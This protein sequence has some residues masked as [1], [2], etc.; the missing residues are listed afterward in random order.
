MNRK[1][2][3]Y[4]TFSWKDNT[5]KKRKVAD[6]VNNNIT[7]NN[8]NNLPERNNENNPCV[9]TYED[10]AYVVI[11]PRNVGKTYYMLKNLGKRGNKRPIYKVTRS[12]NQYPIYKTS[13]DI[14]QLDKY[15]GSVV[16]FDDMLGARNSF[17]I[18]EFFTR[19]RHEN[20][21]V[22]HLSH[23]YFGLP[24]QKFR[25]NSDWLISFKQTLRDVQSKYYAIGAY[26]MKYD[27][28]KDM[29]HF[30]WSENFNYLCYDL[31]K[32]KNV[33][34]NRIFNESKNTYIECIPDS[35]AFGFCKCCLRYIIEKI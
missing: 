5:K 21:S 29:C 32:N 31:T 22:Y 16:I 18:N 17:Q 35:A 14:K 15:K 25:K 19:W 34:K 20:L 9:S 2:F 30:A 12:S 11:G 8:K 3:N 4:H 24:R 23:S 7:N 6:C 1:K 27:E 10:H 33:G 26:D 13:N 28:F